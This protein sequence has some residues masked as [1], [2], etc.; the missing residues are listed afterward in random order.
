MTDHEITNR[1][2]PNTNN[3]HQ[4][5]TQKTNTNPQKAWMYSGAPKC[6]VVSDPLATPVV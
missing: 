4:N 6:Y 5:T 3:D 1:K 2:G